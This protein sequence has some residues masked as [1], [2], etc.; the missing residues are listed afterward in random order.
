M[1]VTGFIIFLFTLRK[2]FMLRFR[3]LAFNHI[4]LFIVVIQ[5]IMIT[6]NVMNG[7]FWFVF[8]A[9][10]VVTN[11]IMAYVFGKLI[12]KHKITELSPNKTWE[13]YIG[14]VFST[15]LISFVVVA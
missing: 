8:P 9:F 7:L 6:K 5:G 2:P 13:G 14:G 10:L 11:D 15:V 3:A 12:G 1:Y 4:V